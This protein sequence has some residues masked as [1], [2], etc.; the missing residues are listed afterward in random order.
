MVF[1]D[2]DAGGE[3]ALQNCMTMLTTGLDHLKD[4]VP[5]PVEALL[6]DNDD[7]SVTKILTEKKVR[8]LHLSCA[9]LLSLAVMVC[10]QHRSFRMRATGS[11]PRVSE[12]LV[13]SSISNPNVQALAWV[14]EGR[15]SSRGTDFF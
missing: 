1:F 8:C 14:D 10:W 3:D 6:L 11:C 13:L 15:R 9:A 2:N 7:K 4:L 12:A 5:V